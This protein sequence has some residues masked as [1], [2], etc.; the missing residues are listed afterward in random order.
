MAK[1]LD[2]L[3]YGMIPVPLIM[4]A[5][6]DSTFKD[7]LIRNPIATLTKEGYELQKDIK[8]EIKQNKAKH[9]ILVLPEQ[10]DVLKALSTELLRQELIQTTKCAATGTCD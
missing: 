4:K 9:F 8:I 7:E 2:W 3:P 6:S 1:N 10:P 5:W